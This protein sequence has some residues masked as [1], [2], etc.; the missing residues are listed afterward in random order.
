MK[1]RVIL[2]LSAFM[3]ISC[4][5]KEGN[6]SEYDK[7][8]DVECNLQSSARPGAEVIVRW[9]GFSEGAELYLKSSSG[10]TIS[11]SVDFLSAS[12]LLF[13]VPE[14]MGPGLYTLV[15]ADGNRE[16]GQIEVLEREF[17]VIGIKV[18]DIVAVGETMTI[19]GNG[20]DEYYKICLVPSSGDAVYLDYSLSGTGISVAIPA[21]VDRGKASLLIERGSESKLITESLLVTVRKKLDSFTLVSPYFAPVYIYSRW[22]MEYDEND[23]LTQ[24][25][26]SEGTC[27]D[28]VYTEDKSCVFNRTSEFSIVFDG[29][30][31]E[32]ITLNSDV[33]YSCENG[34][35][36]K[37]DV[38]RIGTQN[39][40]FDMSYDWV[41][42]DDRLTD[43]T[44]LYKDGRTLY[45]FWYEYDE[46]GNISRV[47]NTPYVYGDT[48]LKNNSFASDPAVLY[49]AVS[50]KDDPFI[51]FPVM[52]GLADVGSANLPTAVQMASGLVG[53]KNIPLE[54]GFDEDGYVTSMT[55]KGQDITLL[56][57][58]SE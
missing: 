27:E 8:V 17:S 28:G 47:Y 29:L 39:K 52:M 38:T 23:Y 30:P 18:P 43:I 25:I 4:V 56:I 36:V 32:N 1:I 9:P 41:Y 26:I 20:F 3:M 6:D 55:I 44:Y 7:N 24:I 58:Y 45:A 31:S 14:N 34:R 13:T 21:D 2:L 33:S 54:Y 57:S 46:N 51:F 35:I 15:L 37:S 10:D 22:M 42:V 40:I 11:V 48:A 16:L 50:F 5:E 49:S 12:G 19:E 53:M